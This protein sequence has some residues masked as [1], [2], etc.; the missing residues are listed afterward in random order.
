MCKHVYSRLSNPRSSCVN[1]FLMTSLTS[2]GMFIF[3]LCVEVPEDNLTY[4]TYSM[5]R[6]FFTS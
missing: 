6:I 2:F 1:T 3:G 5:Q 4:F